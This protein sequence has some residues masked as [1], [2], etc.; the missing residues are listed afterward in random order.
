MLMG[1]GSRWK[2]SSPGCWYRIHGIALELT[3]SY[4]DIS[5]DTERSGE[6]VTSVAFHDTEL[7]MISVGVMYAFGAR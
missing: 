5:I 3:F 7:F 2:R 6:G 1:E 4:R